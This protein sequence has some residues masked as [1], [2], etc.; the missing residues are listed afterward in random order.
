MITQIRI[1][2]IIMIM[3][4][5]ARLPLL[6]YLIAITALSCYLQLIERAHYRAHAMLGVLGPFIGGPIHNFV[7]VWVTYAQVRN[8]FGIVGER[9]SFVF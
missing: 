4:E 8:T 7:A 1:S 5:G 2:I 6:C 3:R 9:L